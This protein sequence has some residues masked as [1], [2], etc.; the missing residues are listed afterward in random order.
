MANSWQSPQSERGIH[1]A[2]DE[3]GLFKSTSRSAEYL[4]RIARSADLD[5]PA[6]LY[7][8]G[9]RLGSLGIESQ[10]DAV[11]Q[12]DIC[13]LTAESTPRSRDGQQSQQDRTIKEELHGRKFAQPLHSPAASSRGC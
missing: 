11:V 4:L 1:E 8:H 3:H 12:D 10:D 2:R 7:G 9:L 13:R 5:D 6:I